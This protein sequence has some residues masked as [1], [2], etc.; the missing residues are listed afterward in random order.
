MKR[1]LAALTAILLISCRP[2]P[3]LKTLAAPTGAAA[4]SAPLTLKELTVGF[5]GEPDPA[6]LWL[7]KAPEAFSPLDLAFESLLSLSP[8]WNLR[9]G[10]AS[11]EISPEATAITFTLNAKASWHSGDP[12]TARDAATFL[13]LAFSPERRGPLSSR[14]ALLESVK[15]HDERTFTVALREPNCSLITELG[16]LKLTR[17]PS[18][19]SLPSPEKLEGTGPFT[20]VRWGEDE[21]VLERSGGQTLPFQRIR[22][23]R[24]SSSREI[25][26]AYR[27]GKIGAFILKPGEVALP[28]D[29]KAE[30]LLSP[31]LYFLT[32]NLRDPALEDAEVR[33]ALTMAVPREELLREVLGGEGILATGPFLPGYLPEEPPLPPFNPARAAAMLRE[34]GWVDEDG[35]GFLEK[36]GQ[37]LRLRVLANGESRVR[38]EIALRVVRYYRAIGVDAELNVMEWGNFLEALFR[39]YFQ[40]A[41]FSLPLGPDPD[42]T[43]LFS[44]GGAFNFSGFRDLESEELM[45][46]GLKAPGCDPAIRGRIYSRLASRLSELK[47]WDFLFFPYILIGPEEL[48]RA[49]PGAS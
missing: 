30:R 5:S 8:D 4:I 19:P 15:V 10:L 31:E 43:P 42:P 7:P 39:G 47:P 49:I 38:E 36:N 13:E 44:T 35:D 25:L 11:F 40:V 2:E 22:F 20:I 16:L 23:R 29:L 33:K 9:P 12:L 27:E 32:F 45:G 26:E 3:P 21:I 28:E 1:V 46:E 24:F 17:P 18:F 48:L 14:S 34:K 6:W 37:P 41:V